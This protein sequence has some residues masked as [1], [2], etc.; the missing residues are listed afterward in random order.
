VKRQFATFSESANDILDFARCQRGDGSFYGTGGVCRLG[1]DA[2]QKEREES[3]RKGKDSGLS[4]AGLSTA[5]K[6]SP[7]TK[8]EDSGRKSKDSG[9]SQA[10]LSTA[11]KPSLSTPS[12]PKYTGGNPEVLKVTR[13]LRDRYGKE[14]PKI[15]A[16]MQEM[17]NKYGMQS[18][19][20]AHRIKSEMSL[21]RK[22]ESEKD[23]P[24]FGGDA[25]KAAEDMSDV[26]RYTMRTQPGEYGKKVRD[27]IADFQKQGY[28][29]RVKNYWSPGQPYRGIN[30]ALT[31]KEGI[32]VELQFHTPDSLRIKDRIHKAYE[33]FRVSKNDR[34]RERLFDQMVKISNQLKMPKGDVMGVGEIKQLQFEPLKKDGG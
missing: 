18:V 25:K 12:N 23:H 22:I 29:A 3:K 34:Q 10:G 17:A 1:K 5:A 13:E 6:P 15:T 24:K 8:Q 33:K 26:I 11:A 19:G 7:S 4:Q 20:L 2:G 16:L 9:L 30:V 21:G 27:T 31:S 32:K 28:T 14:E